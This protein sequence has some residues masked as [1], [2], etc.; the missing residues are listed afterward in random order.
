MY[1]FYI[2]EAKSNPVL[3]YNRNFMKAVGEEFLQET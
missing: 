3:I 1:K 2:L